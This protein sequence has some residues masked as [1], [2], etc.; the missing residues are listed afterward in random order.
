M[1]KIK[2][3]LEE[4]SK[5]K[6]EIFDKDFSDK[7]FK[8]IEEVVEAKV[9]EKY[10]K[11]LDEELS[12]AKTKL[13]KDL[14]TQ[15]SEET[16]IQMK[17]DLDKLVNT[18][19]IFCEEAFKEFS[20]EHSEKIDESIKSNV[21]LDVVE[22]L[23]DVL[24]EHGIKSNETQVNEEEWQ[25]KVDALNRTIANLTQELSESNRS[26]VAKE[27]VE[28]V[29]RLTD[30]LTL[31]QKSRV[32]RLI[33]DYEIDDLELF[34]KKVKS[35][36]N[37]LGLSE[38]DDEDED[39]EDEDEDKN[40]KKKKDREKVKEDFL[41]NSEEKEDNKNVLTEKIPAFTGVTSGPNLMSRVK[42]NLAK[43]LYEEK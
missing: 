8:V 6:P 7:L 28:I 29:E 24:E 1:D 21:S 14:R 17:E 9:E 11:K 23:R 27:A 15:I 26:N 34:E 35:L 33:E 5:D 32:T 31:E 43:K 16:K 42:L 13:E 12:E 41:R 39:E 2:I 18:L 25:E 4:L 30:D 22:K 3:L 19:D 20:E 40:G 10:S 37:L 38:Q 36:I